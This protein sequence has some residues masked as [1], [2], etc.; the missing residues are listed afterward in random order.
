M[1]GKAQRAVSGIADFLSNLCRH[2]ANINEITGVCLV[3]SPFAP[4]SG[5][6]IP[7]I[8]EPKSTMSF[9]DVCSARLNMLHAFIRK[10]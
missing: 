7:C 4:Q 8:T 6:K 1:H 9:D 5:P 10:Y 3:F 2:L